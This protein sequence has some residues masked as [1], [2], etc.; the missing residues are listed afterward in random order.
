MKR[1]RWFCASIVLIRWQIVL[2]ASSRNC[3]SAHRA[4]LEKQSQQLFRRH[5]DSA[6]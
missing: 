6:K 5:S 1:H 2:V 4:K 3:G